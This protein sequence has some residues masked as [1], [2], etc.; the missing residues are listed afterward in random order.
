MSCKAIATMRK[1]LLV[2]AAITLASVSLV[3]AKAQTQ[4]NGTLSATEEIQLMRSGGLR[5]VAQHYGHYV[6][7]GFRCSWAQ[8]NLE[9]L[10]Q[11]SDIIIEAT[12][13]LSTTFLSR[14]GEDVLSQFILEPTRV[15]KQNGAPLEKLTVVVRGGKV[16]FD[17]GT[18]V[19]MPTPLPQALASGGSFLFFLKNSELGFVPVG[20]EQG[21]IAIDNEHVTITSL[22]QPISPVASDVK[23]LSPQ[24]L[25][26]RVQN[27]LAP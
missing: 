11:S 5:A 20:E 10:V 2:L 23:G 6:T 1:A 17:D 13:K 18:F 14:S 25:I 7:S 24:D 4:R 26:E 3:E 19:E 15:L 12:P 21:V 16:T 22:G 8:Y 27:L 9:G